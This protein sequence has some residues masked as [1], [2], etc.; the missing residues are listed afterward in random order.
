MNQ[1]ERS[2]TSMHSETS[3]DDIAEE[4]SQPMQPEIIL[5]DKEREKV[6]N[7]LQQMNDLD[8]RRL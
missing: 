6:E 7:F 4:D 2:D 3:G 5:S 1:C 8:K